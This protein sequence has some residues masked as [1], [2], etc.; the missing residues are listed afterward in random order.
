VVLDTLVP[1]VT[2]NPP[3]RH[4]PVLSAR[5]GTWCDPT[6]QGLMDEHSGQDRQPRRDRPEI[7][8]GLS[9]RVEW[10]IGRPCIGGHWAIRTEDQWT[11]A[12]SFD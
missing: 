12:R 2:L 10:L 6:V 1:T 5:S 11:G 9:D 7:G 4:T 3:K 8:L